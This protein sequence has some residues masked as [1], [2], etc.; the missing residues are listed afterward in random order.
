MISHLNKNRIENF[1]NIFLKNNLFEK[2]IKRIFKFSTNNGTN[3][4]EEFFPTSAQKLRI[5]TNYDDWELEN[6]IFPDYSTVY[7]IPVINPD[8]DSSKDIEIDVIPFPEHAGWTVSY[9]ENYPLELASIYSNEIHYGKKRLVFTV[10]KDIPLGYSPFQ[11]KFSA[12]NSKC[13]EQIFAFYCVKYDASS[14]KPY[15]WW[16]FDKSN[17][18]IQ[19]LDDMLINDNIED[20]ISSM[21]VPTIETMAD[22]SPGNFDKGSGGGKAFVLSRNNQTGTYQAP[23]DM[24]DYNDNTGLTI[25][26]T[27]KGW[28]SCMVGLIDESNDNLTNGNHF[29]VFHTYRSPANGVPVKGNNP[30]GNFTA[31]DRFD[32]TVFNNYTLT[33]TPVIDLTDENGIIDDE[34]SDAKK[35]FD[36]SNITYDDTDKC[37]VGQLKY[38]TQTKGST[39]F[40]NSWPLTCGKYNQY[41]NK[42]E[43]KFRIVKFYVN[44]ELR[45]DG[46]ILINKNYFDW[47]PGG[48]DNN[49]DRKIT[50]KFAKESNSLVDEVIDDI[51]I[52][53]GV[54]PESEIIKEASL[55]GFQFN[56]DGSL[57]VERQPRNEEDSRKRRSLD[58]LNKLFNTNYKKY[59]DVPLEPVMKVFI[60]DSKTIA[61]ACNFREAFMTRLE[62]EF[63]NIRAIDHNFKYGYAQAYHVQ[64]TYACNVW[65]L[66]RNYLPIIIERMDTEE[67]FKIDGEPIEK[68]IGRW[69]NSSGLFVMPS[70]DG[71]KKAI[72]VQAPVYSH[73]AYIR[74]PKQMKSGETHTVSFMGFNKEFKYDISQYCSSIKVNQVGYSTES[75]RWY[76]YWG[77]WT[78]IKND[79]TPATK[80][81]IKGYVPEEFI[82]ENKNFYV[83]DSETG[84]IKFTGKMKLRQNNYVREKDD[85]GRYKY[86]YDTDNYFGNDYSNSRP[87]FHDP[88]IN[89]P[90]GK[91][92]GNEYQF[93]GETTYVLDFSDFKSSGLFKEG[94]YKIYIPDVGWSHQFEI[95]KNVM[96]EV[97]YT[98]CRALFHH[99]SGCNDVRKPFTNW[100]YG[101]KI[102]NSKGEEEYRGIAH[103]FT[104]ESNYICDDTDYNACKTPDGRTYSSIFKKIHFD[105]IPAQATG[106]MFREIKGGWF[107]AADFD[108][109]TYHFRVIIDLL[110]AFLLFPEN[111]TDNQLNIPE[112]NNGI[113]DILSEAEW[114][115]KYLILGQRE[116]GAI[117][118]WIETRQHEADWPWNSEEKYYI[119]KHNRQDSLRYAKCASKMARALK[120]I[121]T[122]D[123]LKKSAIYLNSAIRAFDFGVK[124]ENAAKLN[125]T[126]RDEYNNEYKFS[127]VETASKADCFIFPAAVSLFLATKEKRFLNYI[128]EETFNIH[129]GDYEYDENHWASKFCEEL[130]LGDL[131]KY[132]PVFTKQV[133]TFILG[134]VDQW[135]KYQESHVYHVMNWPRNHNF[136]LSVGWG[137]NHPECRGKG[138][139]YAYKLTKD[140]K[141]KDAV[142]LIMDEACGCNPIGRTLTSGVGVVYPVHFLDSW[143]KEAEVK[144]GQFDPVPGISPYGWVGPFGVQDDRTKFGFRLTKDERADFAFAPIAMNI[145]PGG[146]SNSIEGRENKPNVIANDLQIVADWL[147]KNN[148]L[149]RA[150]FE[151]EVCN[152]PQSEFTIWETIAGKAFL[153]GF[154]M[155]EGW[156]PSEELKNRT[157]KTDRYEVEGY[158]YLP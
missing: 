83:V 50:I 19:T 113:P 137:M 45:A 158:I 35:Y 12:I 139:V 92:A 26:T 112:S 87:N 84:A 105:M 34:M 116:D 122:E 114:G 131:E 133:Q 37:Y 108:R 157:P 2:Q 60:I 53:K 1:K 42:N 96:G 40:P 74:L 73:F 147:A 80:D 41:L 14:L 106:K 5:Q 149:E 15:L 23:I 86:S 127:Y 10:P 98:N 16:S 124:P 46:P 102:I 4:V 118:A 141:Y 94:K 129:R 109:R 33:M 130:F 13:E 125:I 155:H 152:P 65:D 27:L 123:A 153:A 117:A 121:G 28:K 31:A 6:R 47:I 59:Q 85:R 156:K 154:L 142:F 126:Q 135:Y 145:L 111:Y 89:F 52:F 39:F 66:Y 57:M 54:V 143:I 22:L 67:N 44:G 61:V 148:P 93:T 146:Y 79:E 48:N 76:A 90:G 71:E 95:S 99:R 110:N 30:I 51:K 9:S 11:I 36:T 132:F 64:Y 100:E 3:E 24:S 144:R 58:E 140:Q 101:E 69:Q 119:G 20:G 8:S 88:D 150:I 103:Q 29:Y 49:T 7:K 38:I 91:N 63:P 18:E 151:T 62:E 56:D 32:H 55:L 128:N 17:S 138:F 115:L 68:I 81:S 136:S 70:F 97:F 77:I 75:N 104:W 25:M 107:D 78:G 120:M 21:F 134:K 43:Y 72:E 82:G